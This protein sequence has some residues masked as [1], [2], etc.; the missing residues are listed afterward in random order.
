MTLLWAVLWFVSIGAA[1]C[2]GWALR[3][4]TWDRW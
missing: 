4:I 2:A 1:F 3:A